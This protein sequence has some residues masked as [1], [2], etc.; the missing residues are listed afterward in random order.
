MSTFMNLIKKY[1]PTT[2]LIL[3]GLVLIISF[4]KFISYLGLPGG[5]VGMDQLECI[6]FF[7]IAAFIIVF[8]RVSVVYFRSGLVS[9]IEVIILVTTLYFYIN[10]TKSACIIFT[11]SKYSNFMIIYSDKGI[12]KSKF[13]NE[14][15][16]NKVLFVKDT[17]I[18]E[19]NENSLKG[20][21][22]YGEIQSWRSQQV[23]KQSLK[24][25]R[26]V[27]YLNGDIRWNEKQRDSIINELIAKIKK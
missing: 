20:F 14:G 19:I 13:R 5:E 17:N 6:I 3:G 18:I 2:F 9:I 8:D 4:I 22:K 1:K 10:S 24:N 7:I 25:M 16:L 15:M 23:C 12:D 26:L 27:F 21:Y 11:S